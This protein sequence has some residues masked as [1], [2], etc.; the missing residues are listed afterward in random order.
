[1]WQ[2]IAIGLRGVGRLVDGDALEPFRARVAAL[3]GPALAD[4]GWRPAAGEGD[5]TAKLRGLLVGVLA[6]L[7]NDADAQQRCRDLVVSATDPELIAAATNAIAAVGTDADYDE[8]L[9][10]FRN[11]ATPQEELRYMY[12]LAEFP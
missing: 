3:V 8:Y 11:P 6:V 7:G 9:Q 10:H 5:L 2:A 12:A 1:M 4:L